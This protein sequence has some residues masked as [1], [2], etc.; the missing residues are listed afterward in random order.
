[1]PGNLQNNHTDTLKFLHITDTHLLDLAEEAFHGRNTKE[2]LEAVLL[3]SLTRYP[4][5]DFMLFTGDI[6]QTGNEQSYAL[7]ESVHSAVV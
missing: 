3:H 7:F 5:I 6:S 1:M 4:D 2:S